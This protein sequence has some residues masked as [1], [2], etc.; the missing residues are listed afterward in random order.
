M[1]VLAQI[2]EGI[3][4]KTLQQF[5]RFFELTAD[6]MAFLLVM[7]RKGYYNL[8][9]RDKLN[10]QQSE[11]FLAVQAVYEQAMDTLEN[12]DNI[13]KWMHTHHAYL[14]R[15]PFDILDTFIGCDEVRSELIRL[16]HGITS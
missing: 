4:A 9:E 16:D 14:G 7:S 13:R 11:R 15:I 6:E 12:L 3:A 10:K 1:E 5:Q 2:E 8:L